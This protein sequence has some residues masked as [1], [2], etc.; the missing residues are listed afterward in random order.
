LQYIITYRWDSPQSIA[1]KYNGDGAF[2]FELYTGEN[3]KT[4]TETGFMIHL[5]SQMPNEKFDILRWN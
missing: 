2:L 3:S 4:V 5:L 1:K